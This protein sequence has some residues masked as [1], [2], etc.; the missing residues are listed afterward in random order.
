MPRP[1]QSGND[2]VDALLLLSSA[3]FTGH[4]SPWLY[5]EVYAFEVNWS[6]ERSS[7]GSHH[8]SLRWTVRPVVPLLVSPVTTPQQNIAGWHGHLRLLS[9]LGGFS[10]LLHEGGLFR[11]SKHCMQQFEGQS[12][13]VTTSIYT[14]HISLITVFPLLLLLTVNYTPKD[15]TT[16]F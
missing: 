8:P 6:L 9:P 4:W 15:H 12:P 5:D 10:L 3:L 13:A 7:L 11:H 1:F 16:F 14:I 2:S